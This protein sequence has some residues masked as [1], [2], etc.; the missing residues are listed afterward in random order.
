MHDMEALR[1]IE[2][3]PSYLV[4]P[5]G[6]IFSVKSGRLRKLSLGSAGP[7]LL[8][9]FCE[10][11]VRSVKKV[12]RIVAETFIPNPEKKPEVNHIDGDKHNNNVRNLEWVTGK[13]NTRH[14]FTI[15]LRT[16]RSGEQHPLAKLRAEDIR[17][18]RAMLK[19]G[20][21]QKEIA[22]KYGISQPS[23]SEIKTRRKW[24]S[25]D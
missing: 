11:N 24:A 2:G 18:I 22:I 14:A 16:G 5:E 6:E 12:H 25:V 19:A 17:E 15:G 1:P 23:I 3:H 21:K 9:Q 10:Y 13:E 4:T 7:Y 8:A 20:Y